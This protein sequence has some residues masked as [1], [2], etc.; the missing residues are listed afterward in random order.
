MEPASEEEYTNDY[1]L[2][3]L[4]TGELTQIHDLVSGGG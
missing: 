4:D 1:C 3:N 2:R